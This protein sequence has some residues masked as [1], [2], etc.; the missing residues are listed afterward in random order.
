M[1]NLKKW[2]QELLKRKEIKK[3]EDIYGTGSWEHR[4]LAETI[5][6]R[7]EKEE[8]RVYLGWGVA[9]TGWHSLESEVRK[10]VKNDRLEMSCIFSS[11]SDIYRE[12]ENA[13]NPIRK[14][15]WVRSFEFHYDD[16]EDMIHFQRCLYQLYKQTSE[17]REILL[18]CEK[19]GMESEA[20]SKL[21]NQI[22]T[23][24]DDT[25]KKMNE[26]LN[27]VTKKF[28]D[29][30]AVEEAF[31]EKIAERVNHLIKNTSKSITTEQK[32]ERQLE[33]VRQLKTVLSDELV[34]VE[35]KEQAKKTLTKIEE[36]LVSLEQ[37]EKKENAELNARAIITA[38]MLVH[39]LTTES[40]NA[41][42]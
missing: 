33:S 14:Y 39:N 40:V 21:T 3:Y 10:T 37:E 5:L 11:F 6:E 27:P 15:G 41:V 1:N 18:E 8:D 22:L 42:K 32:K 2:K 29:E 9:K 20:I 34:S 17:Y 30:T 4:F 26:I 23:L 19:Q 12:L 25:F 31:T 35:T 36:S 7:L 24:R 13:Y 16:L 38:S 28:H